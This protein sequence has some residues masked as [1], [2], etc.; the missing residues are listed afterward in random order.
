MDLK[1][2]DMMR[3]FLLLFVFI[4]LSFAAGPIA[5]ETFVTPKTEVA[6]E[7]VYVTNTGT[8]YHKG[9]CHHL[10]KSKIRMSKSDA[11]RKGYEACK[12]CKP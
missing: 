4:S 9:S 7:V 3:Y 11:V 5:A 2:P 8:K 12:H 1:P 10:R 6:S